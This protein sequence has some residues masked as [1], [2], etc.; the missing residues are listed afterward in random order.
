MA[1]GESVQRLDAEAKVTGR[2]RYTS[3]MTLQG[4]KVA[5]YLHS[6]I[7]HGRVVSIDVREASLLPGVEGIFTAADMP[8]FTFATAGHALALDPDSRDKEDRLLL[9]DHIRYRGDEIAVVVADNSLIADQALS[10]IRVE[11]EEYPSVLSQEV[12]LQKNAPEIHK[13]TANLVGHHEYTCG[14]PDK[15]LVQAEHQLEQAFQTQMTQHCHL[16]NHVAYAYM[17]DVNHIVIVTSTQ[18]PH[19]CR[20]IVAQALDMSVSQVRVIKPTIGGG[21]GNKQDVVLEPMVAFLTRKLGGIPIK[22]EMTREECMVNT[23]VRHPMHVAVKSG[24]DGDGTLTALDFCVH[25]NTGAYASH[26]HSIVRAA[27]SKFPPLYP[28]AAI[29][30]EARTYYST[31]PVAGAMRGYGA[32]QII[33]ALESMI[34]DTARCIGMDSVEFRLRNVAKTGDIH[35]LSGKGIE[36]C[37]MTSCLEKGR[38]RINWKQRKMTHS[39]YKTGVVRRGLGVACFSY[40]CGTYPANVEVSGVS[41]LLNQDGTVNI[42]C[43][44][45]E[46]GQGADTAIAQMAAEVIG[47]PV[48]SVH[49]VSTQDTESTPYDPGAFASRMSYVFSQAVAE[50]AAKLRDKILAYGEEILGVSVAELTIKDNRLVYSKDGDY[51]TFPLKDLALDAFYHKERGGQLMTTASRKVTTNASAYGCTFVEVEVDMAL[52]Q[53]RLLD[54]INVHDSGTIINPLLAE[55]QVFGGMGMGIGGALSEEVLVDPVTGQVYN[56]NL[57]DYKVATMQDLPDMACDFVQTHEPTSA[58]GNKSLGEPPVLSVAPAIRNAILDAT[59]VAI[60]NLPMSPKKLFTEFKKA[61]V[62]QAL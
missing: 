11:Y 45:P 61:G 33:F 51:C 56:G 32:P 42:L 28:R 30:Y 4:M 39:A 22:L 26:G 52:C 46:I 7:T 27:G 13:G 14:H 19:I 41:M 59:G 25:S 60:N 5:K 15:M 20:R 21:F 2:A 10:L 24:V 50:A 53:V 49:I 48:S 9:T 31:M 55:G 54:I 3:D 18:I 40:G 35:P 1:I 44:A 34:E 47:I 43:G 29:R 8:S 17:D 57:L 62:L 12:A 37:G 23:R 6:T 36:S 58:F 38:D 16:E